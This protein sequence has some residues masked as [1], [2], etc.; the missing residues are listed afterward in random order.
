[1]VLS[2]FQGGVLPLELLSCVLSCRACSTV[3][4]CLLCEQESS[5]VRSRCSVNI[6]EKDK[7]TSH[8]G[9][10]GIEA[11]SQQA[12]GKVFGI[13]QVRSSASSSA[14][15]QREVLPEPQC[16]PSPHLPPRERGRMTGAP[17]GCCEDGLCSQGAHEAAAGQAV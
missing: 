14:L 6:C 13:S 11:A 8:P 2:A 15:R 9:M 1:M 10:F 12:N 3:P 4:P 16:P 7:Y 17:C 5:H